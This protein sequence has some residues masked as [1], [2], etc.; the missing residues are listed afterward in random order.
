VLLRGSNDAVCVGLATAWD[1]AA[2]ATE[3][4]DAVGDITIGVAGPGAI[5][6]MGTRP[7]AV[8]LGFGACDGEVAEALAP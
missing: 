2:D 1:T 8:Y 5:V 4:R 3:F 7:T 6:Q